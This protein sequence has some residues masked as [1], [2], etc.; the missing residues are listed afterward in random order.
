[1]K[2]TAISN[3][4]GGV[5]KTTTAHNLGAALAGMGKKVLLIDLDP[6]ASLTISLGLE[7]GEQARSTASVMAR[8]PEP[9]ERCTVKVRGSLE[10]LPSEIGLAALEQELMTRTGR[11]R[12]LARA[13]ERVKVAYDHVLIDCPPQLS[14]L[15][16]NGLSCA[17]E[18]LVPVK[19]DYLAYRGLTQLMD[20]VEEVRELINPG[21]R[22][23]GVI[24]TLY[25][26]RVSDD[27]EILGLLEREYE[28]I[29]TVKRRAGAKKGIYDGLCAVE[30][31][32]GG[33]TA[34]EYME[35]ARRME[36]G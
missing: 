32:P 13:L 30:K 34:R 5:G 4:K 22:V 35:I 29:G 31:E 6:Q 8:R 16:V 12:V 26:A 24:A 23:Q 21:L 1:M 10:L 28:V 33:E 20:T 25:D 18:V 11:E 2:I 36:K 27:R 15:T 19:T 3:Q 7:P 9:L 17:D 14:L